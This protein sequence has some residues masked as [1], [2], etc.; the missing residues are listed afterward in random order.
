MRAKRY[1]KT[2]LAAFKKQLSQMS[3]VVT[4]NHK[5]LKVLG[6]HYKTPKPLL[7]KNLKR[8]EKTVQC[9]VYLL[10]IDRPDI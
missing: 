4:D 5:K 6:E 3:E 7:Y 10:S 2:Q 1:N 9:I 8:Y